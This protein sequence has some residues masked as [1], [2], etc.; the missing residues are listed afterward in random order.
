MKRNRWIAALFVLCLLMLPCHCLAGQP[1]RLVQVST[2]GALLAGVYDGNVSIRQLKESGDFGLGTFN[3]LDGEM[4]F[5]DGHVYQVPSDGHA[6]EPADS[7]LVP[8][9]AVT[10]FHADR[11]LPVESGMDY[12]GLKRML[13]SLL[14]SRN[15]FYAVRIDGK[16]RTVRTR[17]VK[18]QHKPYRPLREVVKEQTIFDFKEARGTVAGFISPPWI[19]G[20]NVPGF[21]L[22]FINSRRDAGGHVLAF[23]VEDATLQIDIIHDFSMLLP[24]DPFFYHAVLDAPVAGDIK[25][26]EHEEHK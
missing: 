20:I 8:F 14:P 21:H 2:L 1:D 9:A 11:V 18:R 15:I 5:V 16:F 6:V 23:Q 19:R 17:S 26:V 4:V 10:F 25:K 13:K 7:T 12:D 22:H 24:D 3:G